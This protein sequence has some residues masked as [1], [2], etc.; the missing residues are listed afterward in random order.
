L[1]LHRH[2][3][4]PNSLRKYAN[5]QIDDLDIYDLTTLEP[6]ASSPSSHT[7]I[8]RLRQG[9]VGAQV[10]FQ[11]TINMIIGQWAP[12]LRRFIFIYHHQTVLVYLHPMRH[13]VQGRHPKDIRADWRRSSI[14]G[15]Q[16]SYFRVCHVGPRFPKLMIIDAKWTSECLTSIRRHT[17]IED[18]F[19]R[20]KIGSLVGLEG[21]HSIGSS[22]AVLRMMY[23]MGVRY[24]TLTHSCPTPW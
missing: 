21:G 23:D 6:W 12:L 18:A 22:L 8:N 4:F 17:G 11:E 5:N 2:N 16:S 19:S 3:D 20:G 15:S 1:C 10:Q 24:M 7:D 9:K 14:G 13:P